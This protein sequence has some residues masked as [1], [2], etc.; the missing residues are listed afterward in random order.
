MKMQANH[1]ELQSNRLGHAS[2]CLCQHSVVDVLVAGEHL[3]LVFLRV[4]L[5]ELGGF[6]VQRAGTT[7]EVSKVTNLW[8]NL[9]SYL[10]GS[11]NRLC[12][13]SKTV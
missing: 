12:R 5:V 6:V 11:P 3:A 10:F 13:L 7:N 2:S 4:L 1:G 9:F 8:G